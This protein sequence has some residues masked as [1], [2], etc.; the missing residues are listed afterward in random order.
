MAFLGD[1]EVLCKEEGSF[2]AI[3]MVVGL[4]EVEFL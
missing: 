4:L 1:G 2:V 3:E